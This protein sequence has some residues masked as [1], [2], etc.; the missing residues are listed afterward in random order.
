M[1]QWARNYNAIMMGRWNWILPPILGT[2]I[3]FV[4]LFMLITG[5]NDYTAMKRGR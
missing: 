5:Y 4:G 2:I 1:I 3:L